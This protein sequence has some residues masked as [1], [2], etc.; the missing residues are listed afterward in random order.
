[1]KIHYVAAA[2][3]FFVLQPFCRVPAGKNASVFAQSAS[4]ASAQ[5]A[6]AQS[7]APAGTSIGGVSQIKKAVTIPQAKRPAAPDR[8]KSEKA[9]L[10]DKSPDTV[11]EYRDTFRYG[12][13]PEITS[14]LQKCIDNDDPRFSDDAYDLFHTTRSSQVREKILEY[15]T[16]LK[17]PCL[18]DYAVGVLDDPY[19]TKNSTVEAVFRYVSAVKCKEALPAVLALLDTDSD[20]YFQAALTTIGEIGGPEE[21]QY[22]AG[23]ID[24]DDLTVPQKQ[25][26]AR[27]LGK[28]HA[29]ETWAKLVSIAQNE[30]ENA[31]VRMYAA[32]AIGAMQKSESIPILAELYESSDPNFRQYVIKGLSY[33]PESGEAKE[34]IMQGIRDEHYKVRLE[35]IAAVKKLKLTEASPYLVYR[36]KNDKEKVV[37][38]ACYDALASLGTKDGNGC[39][40]EIVSDPKSGDTAKADAA[41]ALVSQGSVGEKEILALAGETLK[42]DRRKQLRYALGKLFAKYARAGYADICRNFLL[43]K[44]AATV[45]L[46]LDMYAKAKYASAAAVVSSLANDKKSG[47]NGERA[48]K[49]LGMSEQ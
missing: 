12:V 39:L 2:L 31:F 24:R 9:A 33:Y 18:E 7:A 27:V 47:A 4:S 19:D 8:E 6:S 38:T 28:L 34:V 26:L 22:L 32:E 41:K 29:S 45:S 16:H 10:S 25:A 37:K 23:Y 43:S 21:A 20:A 36:A 42:D 13:S 5:N 14:L 44:D 49:I 11:K 48:R 3:T 35:A 40:I 30:D 17:D 1:M 15:F 46:G